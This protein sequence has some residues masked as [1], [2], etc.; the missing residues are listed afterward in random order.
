MARQGGRQQAAGR[1][2]ASAG[3]IVAISPDDGSAIDLRNPAV[4]AFLSWCVPG[5]GQIYQGRTGKGGVLMGAILAT[6][7]AGMWLGGGRVV[8]A[9]WKPGEARWAYVC[10]AGAGLI[11]MPA[12]LQSLALNGP[13]RQPLLA[14]SFMAP[15]LSAGQ[16][17]S[18]AYADRLVA[19]D[20]DIDP[21]DFF[22]KPPLRQFRVDQLSLWNRRLGHRFEIGTL[23]TMLAGMLNVLVIFDAW[24]GPLGT[25]TDE[26]RREARGASDRPAAG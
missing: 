13:A 16:S 15:P 11:A 25:P 22:D 14:S 7:V 5:L 20:P 9:S 1:S 2:P 18:R 4:A 12:V 19:A 23:Y 24:A 3:R 8:Y 21:D 6:F 10:Q 26:D 17:V